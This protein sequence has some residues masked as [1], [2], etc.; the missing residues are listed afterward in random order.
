MM[1]VKSNRN[2]IS[3]T[4]AKKAFIKILETVCTFTPMF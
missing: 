1:N 2:R 4:G 3:G